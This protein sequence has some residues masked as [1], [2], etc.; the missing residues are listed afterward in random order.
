MPA[1]ELPRP[2]PVVVGVNEAAKML[3][4]GPERV[5]ELIHAGLIAVVPHL[6]SPSRLQIA[7][8]ELERFAAQGMTRTDA[9]LRVA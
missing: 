6:S 3:N 1:A 9:G 8:V 4:T 7:V 5:R 2:L